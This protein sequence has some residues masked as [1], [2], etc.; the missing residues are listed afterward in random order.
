M[1]FLKW[2]LNPPV[3]PLP[4]PL[5]VTRIASCHAGVLPSYRSHHEVLMIVLTTG[6]RETV[7][8]RG[9]H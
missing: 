2:Q 9:K 8:A 6:D 1:E 4:A 5:V 7:Y 3:P